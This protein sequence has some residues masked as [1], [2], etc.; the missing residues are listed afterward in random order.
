MGGGGRDDDDDGDENAHHDSDGTPAAR[1]DAEWLRGRLG[2]L[3]VV[4][5]A[6]ARRARFA[7][8][9]ARLK[10]AEEAERG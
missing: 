3:P 6:D 2:D 10:R 7:A 8:M 5:E 1:M 9:F 4:A